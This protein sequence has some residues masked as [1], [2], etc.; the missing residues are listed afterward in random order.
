MKIIG[1]VLSADLKQWLQLGP[2]HYFD[3]KEAAIEYGKK[4]YLQLLMSSSLKHVP[5]NPGILHVKSVLSVPN[6]LP[7]SLN[8]N[9]PLSSEEVRDIQFME[10]ALHYSQHLVEK[11]TN[12]DVEWDAIKEAEQAALI[13]WNR[14]KRPRPTLISYG[15]VETITFGV[16]P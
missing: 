13:A 7:L 9:E 3:T 16:N 2:E 10:H 4:H 12:T 1:Y 8:I 5:N 11:H 15:D 6:V 14:Q